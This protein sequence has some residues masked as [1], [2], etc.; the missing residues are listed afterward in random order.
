MKFS[1]VICALLL[2]LNLNLQAEEKNSAP[3]PVKPGSPQAL[4]DQ[5][6]SLCHGKTGEGSKELS[7]PS[8]AGLPEWYTLLQ[9]EK[10]RA[11]LRGTSAKDQPGQIMHNLAKALENKQFVGVAKVIAAMP[12]HPSQNNLGGDAERGKEVFTE[13]CAKCHRF[14]GKGEQTFGS[15]PL[16]GLQDW[17]IRAQLNKFREGIRG[18]SKSDEKGF[19]M[20]EMA[21]YLS[22]ENSSDVTAHIANLA[23]KYANTKSRRDREMDE[24]R[25]RKEQKSSKQ[26]ALPE[27]LRK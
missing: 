10:F 6:C 2:Y 3:V 21:R 24:I 23:T 20:H 4:Y 14:N 13:V 25:K 19:K 9:I 12:M 26:N 1:W 5:I 16:I 17:Y 15:A 7:A 11:D 22:E 18:G 8:I 27:E